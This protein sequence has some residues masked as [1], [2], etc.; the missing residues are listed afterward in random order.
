[1]SDKVH[2]WN[3]RFELTNGSYTFVEV[4]CK[5]EPLSR[6]EVLAW[7]ERK[8]LTDARYTAVDEIYPIGDKS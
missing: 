1:M 6:G 7:A 8:A 5:D 3:V 2:A 4:S